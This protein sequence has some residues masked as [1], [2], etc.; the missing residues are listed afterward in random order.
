[1]PTHMLP[2]VSNDII[3]IHATFTKS[4]GRKIKLQFAVEGGVCGR[5]EDDGERVGPRETS[6]EMKNLF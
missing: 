1:M 5:D 3:K 6:F 4:V 2:R